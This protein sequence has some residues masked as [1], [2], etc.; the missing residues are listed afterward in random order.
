MP[1]TPHETLNL[2]SPNHERRKE[3][4]IFNFTLFCGAS[5]GFMKA[6]NLFRHH[7]EV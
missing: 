2:S 6:F 3:T 7:K 4:K 1:N 5:K